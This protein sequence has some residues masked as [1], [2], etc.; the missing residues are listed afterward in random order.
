MCFP[1]SLFTF[2]KEQNVVT[3]ILND[4]KATLILNDLKANSHS[5][6]PFCSLIG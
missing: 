4:L 6:R 3:L 2:F 5:R 1:I